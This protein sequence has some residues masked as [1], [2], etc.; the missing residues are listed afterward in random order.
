MEG[1]AFKAAVLRIVVE[2][3]LVHAAECKYTDLQ[4]ELFNW[5]NLCDHLTILRQIAIRAARAFLVYQIDSPTPGSK[6]I[7]VYLSE[8]LMPPDYRFRKF[9]GATT[10][11]QNQ[12]GRRIGETVDA[13]AH[14]FYISTCGILLGADLQG[15]LLSVKL[16]MTH[17]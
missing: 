1:E 16:K 5:H 2:D 17:D 14:Y 10:S 6:T 12:G 11:G 7:N 9:S 4:C 15:I 8:P 3:F 13:L